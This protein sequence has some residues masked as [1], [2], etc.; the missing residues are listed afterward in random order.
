MVTAHGREMLSGRSAAEQA[1]LGGFLVKPLT[2]SMLFDAVADAR[3]G[4]ASPAG[5]G[6]SDEIEPVQQPLQ[7]LRL[8]VVEDNANNRQV[9]QELLESQGARVDLADNGRDGVAA[10]QSADPPFDAVLMDLQMP[11]MDGYT[12]TRQL[13]A[14]PRWAQLPIIAMTANAMSSDRQECLAAGMNDHIGKPFELDDLVKVLCRLTGRAPADPG[15]RSAGASAPL[16]PEARVLA[17]AMG[18]QIEMAVERMGGNV[19]VYGRMLRTFLADLPSSLLRLREQVDAGDWASLAIGMHTLK[20]LAGMLG[21]AELAR[22]AS[23]LEQAGQAGQVARQGQAAVPSQ[24]A[25]AVHV[26]A[27]SRC[28]SGAEAGSDAWGTL[29]DREVWNAR[30][31]AVQAAAEPLQ[32][33]GADL[34][35]GLLARHG[36][37]GERHV[38][39]AVQ[40]GAAGAPGG[41]AIPAEA[42]RLQ[43]SPQAGG[44]EGLLVQLAGRLEASDMQAVEWMDRIRLEGLPSLQTADLEALGEAVDRL[45]FERALGLCRALMASEVS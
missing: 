7:G 15:A 36:A 28:E 39:G 13:R 40:D 26:S 11:V 10:V 42:A 9:A 43:S 21:A 32:R 45:D 22:A 33:Q 38:A 8:L 35:A 25:A 24:D 5:K 29:D 44:D 2:A 12:A 4:R 20:G 31:D 27:G 19:P 23:E 14:E 17:H 30:I 16:E 18:V 1:A 6:A 37:R 34:V 41:T 3:L